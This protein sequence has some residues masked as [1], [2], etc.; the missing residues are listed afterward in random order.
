MA[1]PGAAAAPVEAVD[2][3]EAHA[4]AADLAAAPAAE[5]D[6]A[7]DICLLT[8]AECTARPTAVVFMA[9][10]GTTGPGTTA[11]EAAA[12]AACAALFWFPSF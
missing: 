8:E 4:A 2:S 3:V 9:A 5:A 12:S 1:D 6:L 10:A 7:A 11:A